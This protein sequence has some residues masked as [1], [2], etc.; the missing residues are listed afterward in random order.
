MIKKYLSLAV[1]I[2]VCIA[3]LLGLRHCNKKQ[4]KNITNT[5]LT[6]DQKEKIIVD[7]SKHTIEVITKNSDKKTFL[8]DRP[9]SITEDNKGNLVVNSRV[10]GTE[11]KP[12]AGIG[13]D[14]HV[15]VHLGA[16]WLYYKKLDLGTGLKLNPSELKDTRID[17]NLSY[18]FWS[19]TSIALSYD[20][21]REVGCFL[22]LRF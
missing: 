20:N 13:Y 16:D 7:S 3:S 14:G 19:N 15:R 5:T 2:I 6:P 12:Y 10:F 8:P 9:S 21:R 1:I 4:D 22:K 11:A 17:L 18:N